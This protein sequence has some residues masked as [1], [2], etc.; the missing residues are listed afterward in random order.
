MS[1]RSRLRLLVLQVLVLSLLLT[2]L[3][4]LWY[5][6]VL[7]GDTYVRAAAENR[8]R[9]IITPAARG[10]IL[11]ASGRPLARN[12]TALV[13]SISRTEMLR[14][15]DGGKALVAKVAKVIGKP[16]QDVWDSTRLCGTPGAPEPPKCWN[17]SPY[18]PIPVTDE[19]DTQMAL[20]IMER[21]EDFPGVTAELQAVREYPGPWKANA[22]HILG[23]LGPVTDEE[24]AAR[25]N[26]AKGKLNETVLR[27]TDLIGRA[28]LEREYDDDLRG[29][30]GVKTLAV[31]HRGGVSGV[32]AETNPTPGNYL[33]TTIDAKVQATAEHQLL[34]AIL[35][36]RSKGDINKGYAKKLKADSGA[37]VV[38]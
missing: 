22:A 32:I 15:R 20:Q 34:A 21:R 31:D 17:G 14:Q 38:M 26:E 35:R 29:V 10:M 28:G 18:Q 11:D 4:R 8:T 7:A 19:A 33:V 24:L 30:P 6:Q 2:L 1:E 9:E 37:I 25:K 36:A 12:R 16:F 3:G 13:V 27:R 23:Y 5:L